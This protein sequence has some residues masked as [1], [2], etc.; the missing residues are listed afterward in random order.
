MVSAGESVKYQVDGDDT[1]T[2]FETGL[3]IATSAE[4]EVWIDAGAGTATQQTPGVDY[5]VAITAGLAVVTMT[6]APTSSE[7]L[8][9]NRRIAIEQALN[10]TYNDRLP[11]ISIEDRLD[12]MVRAIRDLDARQCIRLHPTDGAADNVTLAPADDRAGKLLYFNAT[13]G[14]VEEISIA[15]LSTLLGL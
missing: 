1:T 8:T 4:I 9:V 10:L 6:T 13:T 14:A 12:Q 11:A 5:T 7:V 3:A 2:E 15:E